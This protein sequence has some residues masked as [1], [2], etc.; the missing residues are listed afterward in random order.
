[1]STSHPSRRRL[2]IGVFIGV[3]LAALL[4]LAGLL[5]WLA[6]GTA[7]STGST[8]SGSLGALVTLI[9]PA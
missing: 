4:V 2:S 9:A 3:L 6:Q 5:F 8:T 1:M 7:P